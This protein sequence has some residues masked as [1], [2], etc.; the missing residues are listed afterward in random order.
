MFTA[1]LESWDRVEKFFFSLGLAA[2]KIHQPSWLVATAKQH[3]VAVFFCFAFIIL[4]FK[5][6]VLN[7]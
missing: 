5:N 6:K 3:I 2:C 7:K 1:L 4:I